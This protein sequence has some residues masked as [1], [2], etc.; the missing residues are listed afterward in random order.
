MLW[1]PGKVQQKLA[2][3]SQLMVM[4]VSSGLCNHLTSDPELHRESALLSS[5]DVILM[6]ITTVLYL[7]ECW[8]PSRL[9]IAAQPAWLSG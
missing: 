9:A 8:A 4:E 3:P 6:G 2:G 7:L 1:E 5:W